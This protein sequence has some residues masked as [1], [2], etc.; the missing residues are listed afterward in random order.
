MHHYLLTLLACACL[1]PLPLIAQDGSGSTLPRIMRYVSHVEQYQGLSCYGLVLTAPDGIPATVYNLGGVNKDLCSPA[2]VAASPAQ[3]KQAFSSADTVA[4]QD[5]F[6]G[7]L[8]ETLSQQRLATDIRPPVEIT[9]RQLDNEQRFIVG[10]GLNYR[11]H[12][13]ETSG[14]SHA[15]LSTDDV[16]V[17]PKALAPGGAYSPIRA[18]AKAGS[19]PPRP[20]LLLDYE[21]ELAMVLLEDLD[22]NAAP[23]GYQDF[24]NSVAFLAAN[25]VSDREPIIL[26]SVHGYT[27]G[28]S[29]PG[30]LPTGP[31]M[32]HGRHLQPRAAAEGNDR[33]ELTLTVEEAAQGRHPARTRRLQSSDTG[34]MILG[35]WQIIRLLVSR[36]QQGLRTCMRD[37]DG[38]PR[39]TQ[40]AAGIIPA[41]SLVLTGTPGGTAIQAPG[42]LGKLDLFVRGGFSPGGARRQMIEDSEEQL[43]ES[44]YLEPGDQV[45]TAITS[46]GK[47]Q[48]RISRETTLVP[49]GI[50]APGDCNLPLQTTGHSE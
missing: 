48:W 30:Y 39:Y 27:R 5:Q 12:R 40:T 36:H 10:I 24:I 50:D 1:L 38:K 31:W 42:L 29:H 25:D 26:D 13:E 4:K 18:G 15:D 37:A 35:P 44:R 7:K 28:K 19:Y 47:Q 6:A 41:G 34:R 17:F 49:Y 43:Q 22:L 45:E 21:I 8:I 11:E 23:P 46:L 32:I 3:L 20:V 33:L 9:L 14:A 16:L 2:T